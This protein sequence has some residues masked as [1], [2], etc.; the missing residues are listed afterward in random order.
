MDKQH[1]SPGIYPFCSEQDLSTQP[2]KM[3]VNHSILLQGLRQSF[4]QEGISDIPPFVQRAIEEG[5][6]NLVSNAV[7]RNHTRRLEGT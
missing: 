6:D 4:L 3:L 5:V 1:H 7:S 2:L